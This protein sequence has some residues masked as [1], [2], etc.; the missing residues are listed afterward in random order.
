MSSVTF[1]Y[2]LKISEKHRF[3]DVFRGYKNVKLDINRLMEQ[4]LEV[5]FENMCSEKCVLKSSQANL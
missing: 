4:P 5:F 2:P 1:L 3:S